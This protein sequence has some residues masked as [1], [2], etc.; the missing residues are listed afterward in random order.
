MKLYLEELTLTLACCL[1]AQKVL[2]WILFVI[3]F[4]SIIWRIHAEEK[5][6]MNNLE[7]FADYQD[8]VRWHLFPKIW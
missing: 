1:A 8:K 5:L 7:N 3:L 2:G 6:L 4:P